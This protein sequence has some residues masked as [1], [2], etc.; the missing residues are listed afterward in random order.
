MKMNKKKYNLARLRDRQNRYRYVSLGIQ[1][2]AYRTLKGF[3]IVFR[4]NINMNI[5]RR[6][7][8]CPQL[9]DKHEI[10][11]DNYVININIIQVLG[12]L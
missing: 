8:I 2:R 5:K 10:A 9:F 6:T 3:N 1:L 7:I 4:I 12:S 11:N